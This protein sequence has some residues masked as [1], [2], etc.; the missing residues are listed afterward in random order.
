MKRIDSVEQLDALSQHRNPEHSFS[1]NQETEDFG[2]EAIKSEPSGSTLRPDGF[3]RAPEYVYHH[4]DDLSSFMHFY[5]RR[6]PNIT[7]LYSAGTS[8]EDRELWVMEISD[9]P[10]VHEPLE[11]E[12]KYVGNM[13]GNEAVGRE[14]LLLYIQVRRT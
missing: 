14:M 4:Y 7:R 6:Y 10:G 1:S 11:P 9:N 3:L 12:F 13:H 8:V 5:H 2:P